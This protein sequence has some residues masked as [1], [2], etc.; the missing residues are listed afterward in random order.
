MLRIW[1]EYCGGESIKPGRMFHGKIFRLCNN[2]YVGSKGLLLSH[3]IW[4]FYFPSDPILKG[5]MIHHKNEIPTDDNI[6]N[7]VKMLR[8]EHIRIHHVGKKRSVEA[9]NKMS[10]WQIGR[11][12]TD[13][14]KRNVG[15]ASKGHV[16]SIETRKKISIAKVGGHHTEESKRKMSITRKGKPWSLARREGYLNREK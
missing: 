2:H 3:A 9:R 14:H 13:E 11:K 15:L 6:D 16:T 10:A 1:E 8:P 4:N 12:L 7:Y 5:E